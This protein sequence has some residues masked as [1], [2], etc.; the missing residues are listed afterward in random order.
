MIRIKANKKSQQTWTEYRETNDNYDDQRDFKYQ[1]QGNVCIPVPQG[2][3]DRPNNSQPSRPLCAARELALTMKF[4]ARIT[5][6]IISKRKKHISNA[7]LYALK[8][9]II[10]KQCNVI[11]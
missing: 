7:L 2:K 9:I 10:K 1:I 11:N 6:H 4:V 8:S 5:V 3:R